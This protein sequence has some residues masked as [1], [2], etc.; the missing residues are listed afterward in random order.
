MIASARLL[1]SLALALPLA[2]LCSAG[3]NLSKLTANA[4]AKMVVAGSSALDR[5][6]DPQLARDAFPASLKT[7]ETF[8]VSTPD[9]AGLLLTL[10]RGYNSYAFGFLEDDLDRALLDGTEE[11]IETYTRR[12]K[13][14]YLR[15]SEYGFRLLGDPKLQEAAMND[16]ADVLAERLAKVGEKQQPALF[17]AAY[18]LASTINLSLDDPDMVGKLATA[19]M[20][21]QRAYELDPTYNGGA[22]TLFF[23][24]VNTALPQALGGRPDIA[25]TFFDEALARDGQESLMVAFLY[26]RYYCPAVQDRKLWDELIGRVLKADINALPQDMRLTNEIARDRARFWAAHV[27]DLILE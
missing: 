16:D 11:E 14:F 8:L 9:N 24:V 1:G 7:V 12:A 6:S 21:M 26:A 23:G 2:A 15:G 13:M 10:A 22:P 4:S 3:C 19:K 5:E 20:M 25:K 18:G 17:W 27:D